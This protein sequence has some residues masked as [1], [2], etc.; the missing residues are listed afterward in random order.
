MSGYPQKI[1][2]FNPYKIHLMLKTTLLLMLA[3]LL[4]IQNVNAFCGFYV[5]KADTEL[6]NEKSEVILTR[7]GFETVLTMSNDFKGDVKDFAMVIPVPTV[8]SRNNIKVVDRYIF[9]RLNGYS[10]PRLVEYYDEHPCYRYDYRMMEKMAIPAI[11]IMEDAS[12]SM[13]FDDYQVTIEASYTV[14]EYDIL[15]LSAQE[16]QGLKRWLTDNGYQIPEKAEAI[17][18]PY[19]K[20]DMKFFVAK[21]NLEEYGQSDYQNL[22]PIQ[23]RYNHP[24]FMLPIR[25]GMANANGSQ[26]LIVY[27][28]TPKGRVE[29]T[30]YQTVDIPSNFNVP[31]F[32]TDQ[33]S[34]FYKDLFAKAYR[35]NGRNA[36]FVEYAW[37]LSSSNYTKCDP[38]AT[39][40]PAYSELIDAGVHW[41]DYEDVSGWGGADYAGDLFFTRLHVRYENLHFPS[42]L[43]FHVTANKTNHQGRY[44]MQHMYEGPINCEEN[45]NLH[46]YLDVKDRRE[47]ELDN[48]AYYAGWDKNKY[49]S[50]VSSIDSHLERVD[51]AQRR[52]TIGFQIKRFFR[53][54]LNTLSPIHYQSLA[55]ILFGI[56][57]LLCMQRIARSRQVV[58]V[59]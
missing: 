57:G 31:T 52:N 56:A 51:P 25:L 28:M 8:L 17:L 58:R 42:D 26:D 37:D 19:L 1:Q 41:I 27:A 24:R 14:G 34:S 55:I 16:S 13:E 46:Y 3:V 49:R 38:C 7:D 15:L 45:V 12:R 43:E 11:G 40:P 18:E 44:V 2:L 36:V 53:N 21:V 48:L 33:F 54:H 59:Q 22:R 47:D 39:T 50:Y 23:I 20:S 35:R 32:V 30:N 5:A 10:G 4:N 29:S 6:F 9:D